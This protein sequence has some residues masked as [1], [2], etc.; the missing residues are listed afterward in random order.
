M[1]HEHGQDV[2]LE[3]N[4]KK[5]AVVHV[6]RGVHVSDKKE[7]ILDGMARIPGLEDRKQHKFLGM[8]ESVMKKDKLV[9]ECAATEYLRRMSV[10]CT[11]SLSDYNCMT[12][13][14]QFAFS[15]L[16]YLM[17]TEQWLIMDLQ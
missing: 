7:M 2:G 9:L 11:S 15:V 5:S 1:G 12:A 14:N 3:W 16:G 10:I 6:R 4:P 8:L 13:S 17:W